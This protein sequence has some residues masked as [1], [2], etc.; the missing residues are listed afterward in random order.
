[1]TPKWTV[2]TPRRIPLREVWPHEQYDFSAWV[3]QN[4]EVVNEQLGVTIDPET[5]S[6]EAASGDSLRLRR[7]LVMVAESGDSGMTTD[8][9]GKELEYERGASAV[10]GMLGA[11]QRRWRNKLGM[12]TPLWKKQWEPFEPGPGGTSRLTMTPTMRE[13]VLSVG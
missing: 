5:L 1:M 9:L 4:I 3:K 10:A 8:E 13:W 2:L 7:A 12:T 11:A 6:P